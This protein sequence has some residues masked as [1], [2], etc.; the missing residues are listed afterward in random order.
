MAKSEAGPVVSPVASQPAVLAIGSAVDS[1]SQ[2]RVCDVLSSLCL[3]L[4][5][6]SLLAAVTALLS[7]STSSRAAVVLHRLAQRDRRARHSAAPHALSHS[8]P[9]LSPLSPRSPFYSPLYAYFLH[10]FFASASL[11]SL[12][13]PT[14]CAWCLELLCA[15]HDTH[16]TLTTL[17]HASTQPASSS[18]QHPA[19]GQP[20]GRAFHE[21]ELVYTCATC[22]VDPQCAVCVEC[23][24]A[25]DH[26]GHD[27]AL[28]VTGGGVCD[29]GDGQAWSEPG[30]C[31]RH[32]RQ[33]G[34]RARQ[35]DAKEGMEVDQSI[36][37]D[38]EELSDEKEQAPAVIPQQQ[39]GDHKTEQ[40]E[41]EESEEE[42]EDDEDEDD[43]D[44]KGDSRPTRAARARLPLSHSPGATRASSS[45]AS[46]TVPTAANADPDV[47]ILNSATCSLLLPISPF[48]SPFSPGGALL[49]A[50]LPIR[51]TG[52]FSLLLLLVCHSMRQLS[53]THAT[54]HRRFA[55]MVKVLSWVRKL[56][57][58]NTHFLRALAL[59]LCQPYTADWPR[60]APYDEWVAN[61]E[62]LAFHSRTDVDDAMCESDGSVDSGTSC[63][64]VMLG[65]C[66]APGPTFAPS[67]LDRV[68]CEILT[69]L[70]SHS[71]PAAA[72][73]SPTT[74]PT[75]PVNIKL[76]LLSSYIRHYR[77]LYL[78]R[79]K[80]PQTICVQ[81]LPVPAFVPLLRRM[82]ALRLMVA[83][84]RDVI[85]QATTRRRVAGVAHRCADECI[86]DEACSAHVRVLDCRHPCLLHQRHYALKIDIIYLLRHTALADSVWFEEGGQAETEAVEGGGGVQL[87]L[88]DVLSYLQSMN[89]MR[90][91]VRGAHVQ[92]ESDEWQYAFEV[93]HD[94]QQIME[95]AISRLK[96]ATQHSQAS[97]KA[98]EP[99]APFSPPARSRSASSGVPLA[100]P[101]PAP[102]A[103]RCLLRCLGA[104]AVLLTRD[105]LA[106]GLLNVHSNSL[107]WCFNEPVE[108]LT[109]FHLPLHRL[110]ARLS[111]YALQLTPH[112][113][114]LISHF[115]VQAIRST[116]RS[117]PAVD[118]PFTVPDAL[119]ASSAALLSVWWQ[120]FLCA[121][122]RLSSGVSEM[123]ARLWLRNGDAMVGQQACYRSPSFA[124][125]GLYAD[126]AA[127]QLAA[128][129]WQDS[130]LALAGQRSVIGR[131]D[132]VEWSIDLY[133]L[134]AFIIGQPLRA[135]AVSLAEEPPLSDSSLL[136]LA[137][138][139]CRLWIAVLTDRTLYA[140]DACIRSELLHCLAV[141]A[142]PSH[143][144]LL[145][146]LPES[147]SKS[148]SLPA[149][150]AALAELADFAPPAGTRGGVYRLKGSAWSEYNPFYFRYM[151]TEMAT[152]EERYR[153]HSKRQTTAHSTSTPPTAA[154]TRPELPAALCGLTLL[155]H[156][157]AL[158]R[159]TATVLQLLY[160]SH[161]IQLSA[162]A[163]A[164]FPNLSNA[165]SSPADCS[166]DRLVQTVLHLLAMA[167]LTAPECRGEQ[168]RALCAEG[169][170]RCERRPL[171]LLP[172]SS[173]HSTCACL[174]STV[175]QFAHTLRARPAPAPSVEQLASV[176]LSAC[177]AGAVYRQLMALG[178][179]LLCLHRHAQIDSWLAAEPR[180]QVAD[181]LT[182]LTR[183][184]NLAW[185]GS[186]AIDAMEAELQST[187]DDAETSIGHDSSRT[188]SAI[189]ACLESKA[190]GRSASEQS[191]VATAF[192]SSAAT[193]PLSAVARAKL[194]AK[195]RQAVLLQQFKL[196][197][198]RFQL[199]QQE[200][201][202]SS[203][204]ATT[205]R[206]QKLFS[207]SKE[208]PGR[209]EQEASELHPS[210]LSAL[211]PLSP[212]PLASPSLSP[213]PSPSPPHPSSSPVKPQP[214]SSAPTAD[215]E[216]GV[217]GP[218]ADSVCCLCL[219]PASADRLL[220][221]V[222]NVHLNGLL[223]VQHRQ[224]M[225]ALGEKV[226]AGQQQQPASEKG[227]QHSGC[228]VCALAVPEH[229]FPLHPQLTA[230]AEAKVAEQASVQQPAE[231]EEKDG[232][233]R[234]RSKRSAQSRPELASPSAAASADTDHPLPHSR[235]TR[236]R[237]ASTTVG[238]DDIDVSMHDERKESESDATQERIG[239]E[240]R[241]AERS[242]PPRRFSSQP[243]LHEVG[244]DFLHH[245][246]AAARQAAQ[247]S[248][249][250]PAFPSLL[251]SSCGHLLH[252][253][254]YAGYVKTLHPSL[255]G[256]VGTAEGMSMAVMF[257]CPACRRMG[258]ACL[259]LPHLAPGTLPAAQ[260]SD[261]SA[262]ASS[263]SYDAEMKDASLLAKH[264][265][266][267]GISLKPTAA[268]PSFLFHFF[269]ERPSV[270]ELL[271]G[272]LAH[273]P[274]RDQR[275]VQLL[276]KFSAQ[277]QQLLGRVRLHY[278][279]PSVGEA[280][281]LQAG[282]TR[283][284]QSVIAHTVLMWEMTNR[285]APSDPTASDAIPTSSTSPHS[286]ASVFSSP[287]SVRTAEVLRLLLFACEQLCD[288]NSPDEQRE[289]LDDQRHLLKLLLPDV[290]ATLHSERAARPAVPQPLL[291]QQ[292]L[293]ILIRLSPL[294]F[295]AETKRSPVDT[296]P[297]DLLW[298]V[299]A[300]VVVPMLYHA[301]ILQCIL[302][303]SHID[304]TAAQRQLL[305][306]SDSSPAAKRGERRANST[307]T[308]ND[309][310][311]TSQT[312]AEFE[313]A[314]HVQ[315]PSLSSF[316]LPLLPAT[317][318][319]SPSFRSLL[320][321]CCM[322]DVSCLS[323]LYLV[324]LACRLQLLPL[325]PSFK[326][327]V[328]VQRDRQHAEA[329]QAGKTTQLGNGARWLSLR[330]SLTRPE[331]QGLASTSPASASALASLLATMT[332]A[333]NSQLRC[334][335]VAFESTKAVGS[336]EEQWQLPSPSALDQSEDASEAT[337]SDSPRTPS[338]FSAQLLS[339]L[340]VWL[341]DYWH[342]CMPPLPDLAAAAASTKL[343]KSSSKK[344]KADAEAVVAADAVA[345]SNSPPQSSSS[346]TSTQS[347]L[348]AVVDSLVFPYGA[349][350]CLPC[351]AVDL[352]VPLFLNGLPRTFQSLLCSGPV[353]RCPHCRSTRSGL[354]TPSS[355]ASVLLCLLC[356]SYV[357]A[358]S[359]NKCH[360]LHVGTCEGDRGCFLSL[361]R[362]DCVIIRLDQQQAAMSA[363][364]SAVASVAQGAMLTD[365]ATS[366]EAYPGVIASVTRLSSSA[367]S[368]SSA[369]SAFSPSPCVSMSTYSY[370]N[371]PSLYLDA[372]GESDLNLVRGRPLFLN[373]TRQQ[374][375]LTLLTQHGWEE[376][377][378]AAMAAQRLQQQQQHQHHH[379]HTQQQMRTQQ[380][381]R[382]LAAA[383]GLVQEATQQHDG[384][385]RA[386]EGVGDRRRHGRDRSR[387]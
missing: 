316:S 232:R 260:Q 123:R 106:D 39:T 166:L 79:C 372:Y 160:A 101:L 349:V 174:P 193:A 116:L 77:P 230:K 163:A 64:D 386:Q 281:G 53:G 111:V 134:N 363:A 96:P 80:V 214:T 248:V 51:V 19:T 367:P 336:M 238:V 279:L 73:S 276:K 282:H 251:V 42:D 126:V 151:T 287:F 157:P 291:L 52:V 326:E 352:S 62:W 333:F 6:D 94:M 22:Q 141:H 83:L 203:Q 311:S 323:S 117:F 273:R 150:D 231:D 350:P 225:R 373:A 210:H 137:E 196:K 161:A 154:G 270:D 148:A 368:A 213:S 100:P 286:A 332:S 385:A 119:A 93:E 297:S 234:K 23:F 184:V 48:T 130:A 142:S 223:A 29:C 221:R 26:A 14:L 57:R 201:E 172:L 4:S 235:L 183:R 90:R 40:Q 284:L 92:W 75:P 107:V 188:D 236:S 237:M 185:S 209:D 295:T 54:Q 309:S 191:P 204:R 239:V 7:M 158:Y 56:C 46:T 289:L 252:M 24:E 76:H 85:R 366:A 165:L 227:G 199:A 339:L 347:S 156:R 365:G 49:D 74:Y 320:S 15:G 70:L 265:L 179:M 343:V 338:P 3:P 180:Q 267:P 370:C 330:S 208:E 246:S 216:N 82:R 290:N 50:E 331:P 369:L 36:T 341:V 67:R 219:D 127:M 344:R 95:L 125:P 152:A 379:H 47:Y 30:S 181:V 212:D 131:Y 176:S 37:A 167:A 387:R 241:E 224:Q 277:W 187:A 121:P 247:P 256:A 143:S 283:L 44:E 262:A 34:E 168:T 254:C 38:K 259:P 362:G 69:S 294:L 153:E 244:F 169:A 274:R 41:S 98:A 268:L 226:S 5:S 228:G 91:I 31:W 86:A 162:H 322:A 355:V 314:Q 87:L 351:S 63:L 354:P 298:H 20:C 249:Q 329:H 382:R 317:L 380:Q 358:N 315:L 300:A 16:T 109:S 118:L 146:A 278:A 302:V 301:H 381:V 164:V 105:F 200:Q 233:S 321:T 133:H 140:A 171:R 18:Q 113:L 32:R 337:S 17:K 304:A 250:L 364:G 207:E 303:L 2:Q 178:D 202:G 384:R 257:P 342:S 296:P 258:N 361:K 135:S 60:L 197:Q 78:A 222:A 89:G 84:L 129:Q 10:C 128:L 88:L 195:E 99:V 12:S 335:Y 72:S 310:A 66:V 136:V 159:F 175:H 190:G 266:P 112:A 263:S 371:W 272:T 45:P 149:I 383:D 288:W 318:I 59:A 378:Q 55:S 192:T 261:L 108:P 334:A 11:S 211:P 28:I 68:M 245:W 240:E 8:H 218:G 138:D 242:E 43:E 229:S 132:V 306:A 186:E 375:L 345:H 122:L 255:S 307:A 328:R 177:E 324:V 285:N 319:S 1:V 346:S 124:L 356:G 110:F 21:G 104:L 269:A 308:A 25:A 33:S 144:T 292:L 313:T 353:R 348:L 58:G 357:C 145:A 206:R 189:V 253:N 293:P 340:Y 182:L 312:V 170:C 198:Q 114:P 102:V 194:A 377:I 374:A 217:F 360:L 13:N 275:S 327:H 27:T 215:A 120:C 359:R 264:S 97:I 376:H 71:F 220:G 65:Y 103:L 299:N 115:L 61:S 9:S 155:L 81:L 305:D 325:P 271:I 243:S 147:L 139:V 173:S 205:V 35:E 280:A